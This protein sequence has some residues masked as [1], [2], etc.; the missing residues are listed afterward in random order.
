[1]YLGSCNE[2]SIDLKAPQHT[3]SEQIRSIH[4]RHMPSQVPGFRRRFILF[5]RERR[6]STRKQTGKRIEHSIDSPLP[7]ANALLSGQLSS[8]GS[9]SAGVIAQFWAGICCLQVSCCFGP[10]ARIS[11]PPPSDSTMPTVIG[12]ARPFSTRNDDVSEI[13]KLRHQRQASAT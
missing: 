9:L 5:W 12:A 4:I 10:S 6:Y 13:L 7:Q 11:L 3:Q 8:P 1:M 2:P